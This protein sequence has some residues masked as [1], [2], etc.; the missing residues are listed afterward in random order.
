[1]K[2]LLITLLTVICGAGIAHADLTNLGAYEKTSAVLTTGFYW[3]QGDDYSARAGEYVSQDKSGS[4]SLLVKGGDDGTHFIIDGNYLNANDFKFDAHID[5][6]HALRLDLRIERM[7]H[8]LDHLVYD[9]TDP[10]GRTSPTTTG[11]TGAQ[12]QVRYSDSNIG[13]DYSLKALT[14]EAKVRVKIPDMPAHVSISYWQFQKEG[15]EQFRFVDEGCS[16]QCHMQSRTREFDR[17]THEIKG[18]VNAHLGK[19][20]LN[21]IH[22]YREFVTD[23]PVPVDFFNNHS[24]F[25]PGAG[26]FQHDADPESHMYETTLQA[27]SS[28]AG[29][30][31]LAG[32]ATLGSRKNDTKVTGASPIQAEIDYFKLAADV[33]HTTSDRFSYNFKTRYLSLDN[34]NNNQID[35]FIFDGVGGLDP[36]PTLLSVRPSIDL[37]RAQYELNSSLKV[38]KKL[39]L[40]GNLKVEQIKRTETGP[41]MPFSSSGFTNDLV[42][43]L[44]EEEVIVTAKASFF[45]RPFATPRS[46]FNG[47]YK[48]KYTDD[49]AYGTSSSD[50]HQIFLAATYADSAAWGANASVSALL[51]K[52]DEFEHTVIVDDTTTP[53]SRAQ[54]P[55]ERTREQETVNLGI[56]F[57]PVEQFFTSFN[58]GYN[59]TYIEQDLMF[60]MNPND[61]PLTPFDFTAGL[62]GSYIITDRAVPYLQEVHN[63]NYNFS[64]Q[65]S[66]L[67]KAKLDLSYTRSLGYYDPDF[68]TI[69][70]DY[71]FGAGNGDASSDGL[72]E[73][74]RYDIDQYG[75]RIGVDIYPMENLEV[76]FDYSYDDYRDKYTN[77]YDGSVQTGMATIALRF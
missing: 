43:E 68:A 10:E 70:F 72:K 44:P 73:I 56:W 29:G 76:A 22:T 7:I 5:S 71:N 69:N 66:P 49:P 61:D 27:H 77:A 21:L 54:N 67:L 63:F 52:N 45:A 12:D 42:W 50:S 51:E 15:D 40:K 65:F 64:R 9:P 46:R 25:R 55:L 48:Y 11:T 39:T 18:G 60:G 14:G 24:R 3:A 23:D 13:D 74:S 34:D 47:W 41:A 57:T 17:T 33:T 26:D 6:N 8:N 28:L 53:I 20:D 37:D 36:D 38:S 62:T 2:R 30:V 19:F 75:A 59:R 58:Y 31:N 4:G 1:M 35:P 32:S 16:T